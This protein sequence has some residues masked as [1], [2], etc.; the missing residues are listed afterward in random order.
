[1]RLV[2]VLGA[3]WLGVNAA[4]LM[5]PASTT[6]ADPDPAVAPAVWSGSARMWF[7]QMRPFCNPVEVDTR[8]RWTPPPDGWEGAGYQAACYGLAGNTDRAREIIRGL[9]G[10]QQWRAVGLVFDVGHPVADAGNDIAAGPIMELVVEFWP[11]HYM[12]L[13]HAGMSNHLLHHPDRARAYLTAFLEHY[14]VDD[15]RT[16][17][18]REVLAGLR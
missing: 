12:A 1:M 15:E 6:E 7:Q 13:Y 2:Y 11:N 18:A 3:L 14:S 9:D 17:A 10:E 4:A 8:M 5:R 16:A